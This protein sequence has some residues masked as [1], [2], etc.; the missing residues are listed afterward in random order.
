VTLCDAGPLVAL[1]DRS[2]AD[3]KRCV[4]ALATLNELR[5]TWPRLTEAM[6][7]LGQE[8]GLLAQDQLWVLVADGLVALH[9]PIDGEWERMRTLMRKYSDS[10]MELADA[11]I[12]SAAERL[13]VRRVFTLD[14]HFRAY[15][16][17]SGHAFDVVP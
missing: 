6:Y 5:T 15:R 9:V 8:G 16:L 14:R 3:H 1:L 2:D 10:P 13:S 17:A 11:S 7:L 4:T 12:V